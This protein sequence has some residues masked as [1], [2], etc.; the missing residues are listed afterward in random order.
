MNPQNQQGSFEQITNA[1]L[2]TDHANRLGL[3]IR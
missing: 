3:E 2:D 1:G